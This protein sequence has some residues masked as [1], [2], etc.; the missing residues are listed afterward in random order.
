M[1]DVQLTSARASNQA[2]FA[3]DVITA[4]G[5]LI[6]LGLATGPTFNALKNAN[7]HLRA[8]RRAHEERH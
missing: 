1:S 5:A 4:V 6:F 3:L 8:S 2:V 7:S